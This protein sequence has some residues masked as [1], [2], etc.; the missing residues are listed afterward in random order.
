MFPSDLI[1]EE[2]REH[3]LGMACLWQGI[4]CTVNQQ[5]I[6]LGGGGTADSV[7]GLLG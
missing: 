4:E 3:A 6:I 1:S 5:V 7:A 2:A